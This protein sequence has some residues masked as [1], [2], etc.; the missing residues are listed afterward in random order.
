[1]YSSFPSLE[2]ATRLL[3]SRKPML[4]QALSPNQAVEGFD[5]CS[6]PLST[7]ILVGSGRWDLTAIA[8]GRY[9]HR[10]CDLAETLK[11]NAGSVRRW[12]TETDLRQR[13]DPKYRAHLDQLERRMIEKALQNIRM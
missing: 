4:R 13:P 11:K 10:I 5:V 8:V 12:L 2:D 9:G 7:R 3:E 1:M 6:V